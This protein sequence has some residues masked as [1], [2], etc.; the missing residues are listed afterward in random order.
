M[1]RIRYTWNRVHICSV[2]YKEKF[3][4]TCSRPR[5]A[6][7][8]RKMRRRGN[9]KR[10]SSTTK[11]RTRLTKRMTTKTGSCPAMTMMIESLAFDEENDDDGW[12]L[13]SD[14]NDD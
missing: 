14:D 11:R 12:E 13:P 1:I 4:Q 3:T 10:T 8:R 6:R 5:E 9:T 7:R 2:L